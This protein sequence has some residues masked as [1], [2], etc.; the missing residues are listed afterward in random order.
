MNTELRAMTKKTISNQAETLL[1]TDWGTFVLSA[2]TDD[3]GDPMP[4]LTLKHPNI[5]IDSPVVVRVHSECLTGDVFHSLK[6]DCGQQLNAAMKII[7]KEKGI[8]IYL[9]QEGRGIGIINKIKAYRHQEDGMDT[10][11][12]NE[13]LG[14][15]VDYRDYSIAASILKSLS[16]DKIKLL[17]NNPEK[18]DD[19][20]KNGITV[21]SRLPLIISPNDIN[22]GY[23]DTKKA[24][25]GHLLSTD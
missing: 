22:R 17:T 18:I 4:H 23:L 25:M 3:K 12:A 10:I 24:S 21:A 1:P 16:I 14:L 7:A 6:C 2:Y 8:L 19:L 20:V 5:D 11:E 13:A 15:K 9:R